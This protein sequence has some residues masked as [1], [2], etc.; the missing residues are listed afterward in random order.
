MLVKRGADIFDPDSI[1]AVIASQKSSNATKVQVIAA[2]KKFAVINN[3]SWTPRMRARR[4]INL[5]IS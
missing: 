1:K 2:Y 3:I 4:W 5:W